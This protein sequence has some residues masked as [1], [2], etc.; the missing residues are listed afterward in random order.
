VV[1]ADDFGIGVE[2]SYGIVDA[3]VRGPVTATSALVVA[4][5]C[6]ASLPILAEAP[7][8]DLGLHIALT[9]RFRPL[10]ATRASGLVGRDG[11]F[12][13]P[14]ALLAACLA[15]RVSRAALADEIGAQAAR[16]RQL[17]GRALVHFDGHHH[18]HEFPVVRDV[19]ADL[20]VAGVLPAVTRVT[21]EPLAIRRRAHGE[22]LRRQVIEWL[23][24]GARACF[25]GRGL[26]AN[27]TLF[28]TF[29]R[30]A[31]GGVFPWAVHLA[32]LPNEGVVEW[33]VH[34]GRPDPALRDLDEY[35]EGRVAEWRALTATEHR[36]TWDRRDWPR[37]GKARLGDVAG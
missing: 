9:G 4:D 6:E 15:G 8:M 37:G 29:V 28:G 7:A 12:G 26:R 13:R 19:V 21:V 22:R 30:A 24:R 14:G 16:L 31:S 35:V 18:A 1:T 33:M 23:G 11:R 10:A 17:S 3:A 32:H 25:A 2:T 5:A 36:P 20:A 27:D 34:P